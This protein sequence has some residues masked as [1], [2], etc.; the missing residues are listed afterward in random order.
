M[1]TQRATAILG[2]RIT[3]DRLTQS[4]AMRAASVR[5]GSSPARC[6]AF[7]PFIFIQVRPY[8]SIYGANRGTPLDRVYIERFLA[9]HADAIRGEVLEVND[10]N[11]TKMFRR[12]VQDERR[13]HPRHE[14]AQRSSPTCASRVRCR[15]RFDC[16]ILTQTLQLLADRGGAGQPGGIPRSGWCAARHRALVVATRPCRPRLL[17]LDTGGARGALPT[18][19]ARL[20]RR[21]LAA[22]ATPA[23][24]AAFFVGLSAE[25][26]GQWVLDATIELPRGRLCARRQALGRQVLGWAVGRLLRTMQGELATAR[27]EIACTR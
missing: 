20:R 6:S 2:A 12:A 9:Q 7:R 13:R 16:V 25:N 14:P 11:Y 8:S 22:A 3:A 19:A 24:H 23:A 17:A 5:S 4:P 26:V 15:E 18:S 1:G 27:P 21:S 10:A